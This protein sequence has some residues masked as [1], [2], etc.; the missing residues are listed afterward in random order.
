MIYMF[1]L[2]HFSLKWII[3]N[4][5]FIVLLFLLRGPCRQKII[6]LCFY[7]IMLRTHIVQNKI[8]A[9]FVL[10][11]FC[12]ADIYRPSLG[13]VRLGRPN[14]NLS[15]SLNIYLR[16]KGKK[17]FYSEFYALQCI[18]IRFSIFIFFNVSRNLT[19]CFTIY[20]IIIY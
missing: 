5:L 12:P 19:K 13:K 10:A 4:L 8:I 14:P 9:L 1:C 17:S 11:F 7:A 18:V 3:K 16:R 20:V 15:Q 6:F 2:Y